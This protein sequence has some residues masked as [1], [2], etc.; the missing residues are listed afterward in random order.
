MEATGFKYNWMK[1][2]ATELDGEEWSM[3]YAMQGAQK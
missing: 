2:A 3:A 1:T